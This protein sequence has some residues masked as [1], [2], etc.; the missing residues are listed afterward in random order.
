MSSAGSLLSA[1]SRQD[2]VIE[3]GVADVLHSCSISEVSLYILYM[4]A[5]LIFA[6][7]GGGIHC[8]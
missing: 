8:Y 2:G 6:A 4:L 3:N 5:Y 7:R 1:G